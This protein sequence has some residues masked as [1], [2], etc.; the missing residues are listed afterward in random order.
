MAYKQR[1][2]NLGPTLP[3]L[4]GS[5]MMVMSRNSPSRMV[6]FKAGKITRP[7]IW[8]LPAA[9]ALTVSLT[10][11]LI[12]VKAATHWP[13]ITPPQTSPATCTEALQDSTPDSGEANYSKTENVMACDSRFTPPMEMKDTRATLM[14]RSPTG[15]MTT[16]SSVGMPRQRRTKPPWL[17]SSTTLTGTSVAN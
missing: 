8:A 11:N 4:F 2:A 1:S 13:P 17:T 15:S 12:S 7:A 14:W 3:V 16:T 5:M 6:A 10:V 9:V